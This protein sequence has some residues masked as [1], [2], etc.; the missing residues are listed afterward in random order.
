MKKIYTS[1]V[2]S[3]MYAMYAFAPSVPGPK[4]KEVNHDKMAAAE[5]K[6]ARKNAKRVDDFS[7]QGVGRR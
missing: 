2:L 5:A 6:R 1:A 3:A 4:I 7:M